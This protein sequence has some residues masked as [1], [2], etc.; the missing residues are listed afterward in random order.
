MKRKPARTILG[1]GGQAPRP[2]APADADR[3]IELSPLCF[4]AEIGELPDDADE[5]REIDVAFTTGAGV[6]RFDWRSGERYIETLSLDPA[7]V[8]LDRIN[9][10]ASLLDS[11]SS[12][13]LSDIVG[14][15][16]PGSAS[17]AKKEGRAR[18]RFS[19]RDEVAGIWQ[20]VKDRIIRFLSVGYRVHKYEETAAGKGSGNKLP[21][22]R[23]IDWEPYELSLVPIPADAGAQTRGQRPAD[24]NRCLIVVSSRAPEAPLMEERVMVPKNADEVSEVI[25]EDDPLNRA[26]EPL[27]PPADPPAEP[28]TEQRAVARETARVQ[29]ILTGCRAARMPQSFA[30]KLI[31]DPKMTLERSQ[32]L[33]LAELEKRGGDDR[34]PSRVPS[35]RP[36][37]IVGDDPLV[38]QRQHIVEALCHR[39]APEI[40]KADGTH[41][42]PL[43]DAA[44]RYRGSSLLD[45]GRML[46]RSRGIRSEG[47]N[48]VELAGAML[49]FRG[50]MHTTSDYALILADVQGKMLRSAYEEAR[51][52]WRP[53]ARLVQLP[54]FKAAKHLQ[55]GEAPDLEEVLEH[56]EF[57][58]GTIVESKEQFALATYGKIFAVTRQ[59]LINDDLEAFARVPMEF[60]RAARRK[61]SDLAW[62]QITSNPAM[63]DGVVLF[64]AD[65]S[66]LSGSADA[67][68]VASIGAG[69][70]SMRKQTGVDGSSLVDISP[71]FLVV[72][73]ALETIADQFVS[74]SLMAS[75]PGSINPFAGKLAVNAE[76]RLDANS[77]TAWYL[78]AAP[79]QVDVLLYGV[80]DGQEGPTIET[81]VGFDVDGVE[82]KCR[83]DV[84]FKVA[85]WRGLYKNAVA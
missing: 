56:G 51:Q 1:P 66:N 9:A 16:V 64:H 62:A 38:H 53:L 24:T 2:A 71:S 20:D 70:A 6:E 48:K 47:M 80:L 77:E 3:T 52:T 13:S 58:R 44:R 37:I 46:L 67:I 54:D 35:G 30:D 74:N 75:A 83:L 79:A 15:V 14:A 42:F 45:L 59:A 50:A 10:G 7:H 29:G 65:H 61:E 22:R 40:K 23:A 72:P 34:G 49:G 85:D 31:A 21:I 68:S 78:A 32:T 69:R 4:R 26:D 84:G 11:H 76:P 27:D 41:A 5:T 55:F 60:G 19:R 43:S 18:V 28:T 12:W 81:R 82:T 17:L 73:V 39:A 25:V 36:E 57:T 33:I 8:R 63:G